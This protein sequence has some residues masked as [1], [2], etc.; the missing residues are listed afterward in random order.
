M[1]VLYALVIAPILPQLLDRFAQ[2]C[3]SSAGLALNVPSVV[4]F[5]ICKAFALVLSMWRA[6]FPERRDEERHVADVILT[7]AFDRNSI[8]ARAL[9]W[10]VMQPG[11]AMVTR[12]EKIQDVTVPNLDVWTA[13][14]TPEQWRTQRFFDLECKVSQ[15]DVDDSHVQSHVD[16]GGVH[17]HSGRGSNENS[18]GGA[19]GGSGQRVRKAF[20]VHVRCGDIDANLLMRIVQSIVQMNRVSDKGFDYNKH[21]YNLFL[22]MVFSM[23]TEE[24]NFPDIHIPERWIT[25]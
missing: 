10:Y 15:V 21:T 16:S 13:F 12:I 1:C 19:S 22:F 18:G 20:S 4:T 17:P 8:E 14:A 5:L 3:T 23:V 2:M 6:L 24:V 7:D 25:V 9:M 11:N